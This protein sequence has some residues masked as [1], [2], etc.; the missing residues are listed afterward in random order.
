[1]QSTVSKCVRS[2]LA[3]ALVGWPWLSSGASL[4][5]DTSSSRIVVR[6]SKRGLLSAVTHD[7]EFTPARWG[8]QV[9]LEPGRPQDVRVELRIDAASLHDRVSR[10]NQ[11]S[12]DSVDLETAGPKVLDAQRYPEVRFHGESSTARGEGDDLEGVLHGALTLHGTTL[13]L[14]V[15]FHVRAD[16]TAYRV[17]GKARFRQ[18]DFGMTPISKAGGTIG[19]DDEIQVEFEL[20]LVPA[21]RATGSVTLGSRGGRVPP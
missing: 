4:E 9:E 3:L 21:S 12:R 17:S 11:K 19:V 1:M 14:D 6:A 5:A 20:V 10:L 13:P 2:F 7:H 18:T 16:S 15:P 8:A